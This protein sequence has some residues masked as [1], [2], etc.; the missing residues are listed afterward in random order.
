L[1]ILA[2]F[3]NIFRLDL[4]LGHFIIFGEPWTL[5]LESFQQGQGDAVSAAI[6]LLTRAFF[7]VLSFIII[8]AIIIWKMGRIYCGWLCPH[9]SV[10][11][12]FND[13]MLKYLNRVTI[14]EKASKKTKGMLPWLLVF[15]SCALMG[16]VWSFSL[17]SYLLPPPLFLP[18]IFSLRVTCFA[19][20]AVPLVCF[21]V[22]SGWLTAGRWWS[23][24]INPEH[25]CV[26]PVIVNVT[27]PVLCAYIRVVS[28]GQNLPVLN[29]VNVLMPVTRCSMIIR[30]AG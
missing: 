19:N 28:K 5:G 20:L 26:N 27:G 22:L 10:V 11:E 6:T 12:I 17:L 1:F 25:S 13:M 7:P 9:F 29:V 4:T 23:A 16:F 15:F 14:W 8:V 24:L 3:L 18:L 2:P 21:K 30:M